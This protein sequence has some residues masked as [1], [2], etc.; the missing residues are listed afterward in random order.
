MIERYTLKFA[1]LYSPKE[2]IAKLDDV[3]DGDTA[4]IAKLQMLNVKVEI[5]CDAGDLKKISE[6][7]KASSH[8]V[9]I[10]DQRK[11]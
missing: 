7:L 10:T 11:A 2:L 9:P 3:K 6:L 4:A 1:P 8:T 5:V